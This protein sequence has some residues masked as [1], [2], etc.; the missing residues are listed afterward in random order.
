MDIETEEDVVR[1][2]Q[3][4]DWMMSVLRAAKT[5]NLPDWWICAGFLRSKIWDTLHGFEERTVLS[6]IDI[7]YFDPTN[8]DENF[9]KKLEAK[10][11][12]IIPNIPWSVKNQARM[13]IVN[14]LQPHSSAVVGIAN[15]PE[16]V[17]AL[18]AKLDEENNVILTAP[19]GIHDVLNLVVKPTPPFLTTVKLRAIYENRVQQKNWSSIWTKVKIFYMEKFE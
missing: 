17:T 10:L 1:I 6:D 13:H 12:E 9:E 4:D 2:I 14:N 16:T 7:I 3:Q 5:L 8:T 19:H 18:G 11:R 15:F